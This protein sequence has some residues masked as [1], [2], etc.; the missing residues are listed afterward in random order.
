MSD[1]FPK[2]VLSLDDG[3]ETSLKGIRWMNFG[4]F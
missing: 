2:Y 1:H 3:F 4:S